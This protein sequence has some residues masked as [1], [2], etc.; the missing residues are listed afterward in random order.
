M[1]IFLLFMCCCNRWQLLV[2]HGR[3]LDP[4]TMAAAITRP[5]QARLLSL[6]RLRCSIFS[7][8]YNPA[9]LRTGSKHLKS[10][11]KG[12]ALVN[13]YPAF[14][15][16]KTIN[17][18]YPELDLQDSDEVERLQDLAIRKARGKG[19][20]PKAKAKGTCSFT[21]YMLTILNFL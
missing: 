18:W 5:T 11:L 15:S 4:T 9:N 1:F 8:T 2:G 14:P 20:P 17:K 7:T 13:Y 12:A 10:R 3:K 6:Q 19:A 16:I 21:W